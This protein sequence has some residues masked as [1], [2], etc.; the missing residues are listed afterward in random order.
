MRDMNYVQMSLDL[1]GKSGEPLILG[2][3]DSGGGGK[4]PN[5]RP[6]D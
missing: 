3:F 2:T 6:K 4:Q 5:F 1:M